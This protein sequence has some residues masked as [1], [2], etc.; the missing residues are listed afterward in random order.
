[1]SECFW[2]DRFGV[3]E[4]CGEGGGGT[5]T[6]PGVYLYVVW[7]GLFVDP[8]EVRRYLIYDVNGPVSPIDPV[9]VRVAGSG[10]GGTDPGSLW[11]PS[12][13]AARM[14][15]DGKVHLYIGEYTGHSHWVEGEPERRDFTTSVGGYRVTS[16]GFDHN[17][18]LVLGVSNFSE[19]PSNPPIVKSNWLTTADGVA[20]GYGD[21]N[22]ATNVFD[23]RSLNGICGFTFQKSGVAWV[24]DAT[25]T[26]KPVVY[27]GRIARFDTA[28]G[29]ST[30]VFD[31]TLPGSITDYR[32]LSGQLGIVDFGVASGNPDEYM[33]FCQ[34]VRD[35]TTFN[36]NV[37][38][39]SIHINSG[40]TYTEVNIGNW[41]QQP[42]NTMAGMA[43]TYFNENLSSATVGTDGN[44]VL[45]VL[46]AM[47]RDDNQRY[48]II[49]GDLSYGGGV[50]YTVAIPAQHGAFPG[51]MAIVVVPDPN[52]VP[53]PEA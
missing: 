53:A 35:S 51:Q 21:G 34:A 11:R 13:L 26:D 38:I 4:N 22:W 39:K 24:H 3:S 8:V 27:R 30:T 14:E 19:Q 5:D 2:M 1:M 40:N 15:A 44:T 17:D 46:A 12:G 50:G 20:L 43:V 6:P 52:A 18:Q 16:L 36:V 45:Y 23:L 9:G 47:Q 49:L 10:I 32:E 41:G 42:Y 31:E 25:T 7:G 29:D 48:D 37:A 28:F 33:F